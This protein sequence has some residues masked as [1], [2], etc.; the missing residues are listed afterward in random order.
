MFT[1]FTQE[2]ASRGGGDEPNDAARQQDEVQQA[3]QQNDDQPSDPVSA[4]SLKAVGDAHCVVSEIEALFCLD[5]VFTHS[6]LP[7]L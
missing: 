3:G 5:A 1:L 2:T 7:L 6:N 4:I